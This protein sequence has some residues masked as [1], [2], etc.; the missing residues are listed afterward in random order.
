MAIGVL[1]FFD[2][3]TRE[4]VI[5]VLVIR[6]IKEFGMDCLELAALCKCEKFVSH[7]TVQRILDH[8]WQDTRDKENEKVKITCYIDYKIHITIND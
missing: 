4:N 5:D 2:K 7:S 6:Y 8:L 3:N 1:E